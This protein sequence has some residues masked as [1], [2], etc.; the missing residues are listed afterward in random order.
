MRREDEILMEIYRALFRA[1]TPSADF[2]ELLKNAETNEFKQKVIPFLDYEIEEHL[3]EQIMSDILKESRV[4][5][6]KRKAFRTTVAL[7]CSP[8]IKIE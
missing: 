6:Y 7:G 2:D 5:L 8:R 3:Y 4:P 1:A